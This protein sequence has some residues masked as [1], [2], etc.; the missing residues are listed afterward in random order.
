VALCLAASLSGA[1]PTPPSTPLLI[2]DKY[3]IEVS[4]SFPGALLHWL[5][6]LTGLS[7]RGLTGGKTRRIHRVEYQHVLGR[8]TDDEL[9]LLEAFAEARVRYAADHAEDEPYGLT[10]A[11]FDA[12]DLSDA[13]TRIRG[14]VNEADSKA[15]QSAAEHFAPKYEAIWKNG[16]IPRQFLERA[17]KSG[18]RK[19]IARF[20]ADVASFFDVP[21]DERPYPRVILVPVPDGAG[22]HAQMIHHTLLIEIR[23]WEKLLDEVAPIVHENAHLLFYRMG[24]ERIA[25]YAELAGRQGALGEE[26]W[27]V[28]H[29]SL[30]TAIGQGVAYERFQSERWSTQ[31]RWYHIETIDTY[32]KRIYPTIRAALKSHRKFDDQLLIELIRLYQAPE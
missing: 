28:L 9:L 20:L 31:M 16:I 13:L 4:V 6:S 17:E 26:A 25:H 30:P 11:F 3:P 21:P 1:S 27:T 29:E 15:I 8:P 22:T 14:L 23:H 24:Q 10:L 32:A 7:G 2:G 19:A 12:A 5:D 18:K